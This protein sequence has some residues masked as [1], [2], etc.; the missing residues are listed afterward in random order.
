MA[1]EPRGVSNSHTEAPDTEAIG[2]LEPN[3]PASQDSPQ[4]HPFGFVEVSMEWVDKARAQG[5]KVHFIRKPFGKLI[6]LNVKKKKPY[7]V[8]KEWW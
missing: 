6:L 4:H 3:I 1:L 8:F 7:Q 2:S 5:N